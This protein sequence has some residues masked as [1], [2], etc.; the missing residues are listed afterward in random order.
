MRIL[1]LISLTL[2]SLSAFSDEAN[3][4]LAMKV[5][6]NLII[7]DGFK[8]KYK[9]DKLSDKLIPIESL[10]QNRQIIIVPDEMN[11]LLLNADEINPIPT[12]NFVLPNENLRQ[13]FL[14]SLLPNGTL[15]NLQRGSF[16]PLGGGGGG[17]SGDD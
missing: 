9:I 6:T 14:K 11:E 15:L 10:F 8:L 7:L 2:F 1:I 16:A 4:P 17:G 5:G 13:L 12:Y 3:Q